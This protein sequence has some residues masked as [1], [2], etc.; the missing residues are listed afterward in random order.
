MSWTTPADLCVQVQRLW[1]RG[2]LLRA[3]VS[4]AAPWPVRLTLKSPSAADLS[5]C[6][7]SVRDWVR[8][9]AGTPHVRIEWREWN[10]RVQGMQ[11]LPAA[12]WVDT[13]EAALALVGK[14]REVQRFEA[15][16]QQTV[17]VQPALREWV[18]RRPLQA[19]DLA[20]RWER[21]LAVVA[22]LQAHPQPAVYLRQVDAQGVDSKFIEAHRGVLTELLDLALP[23]EAVDTRAS[24]TAQFAR[25]FGFLEK[26]V[27][28]RFRLLDPAMPSLPGCH[29]QPDITLDATSF[30]A[31]A[32]PI[33]RLFITENETNFL[34]FPQMEKAIVVFGAGYGWDALARA[35][36]LHRCR[37][38]YWGDIDTHGF[39]ILD[40]LR[41][42]FPHVA[43]LLM[44]RETLLAHRL[45]W[46]E[47]PEPARHDLSRLTTDES[48]IY[49][50]LRFDCLQPRLRLEQER[51][52]Y[53]WLGD[54]LLPISLESRLSQQQQS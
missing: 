49:D 47:E 44:D 36:C 37:L 22:W 8:A 3:S 52:G 19:L 14:A 54:R 41:G 10:H 20:D 39:A 25:R 33:D 32:L 15:L 53:D 5:D 31:L 30:A 23:P 38:Y 13:L 35:T 45:H 16:W 26:P 24:G 11:R 6:F 18:R 12:V 48:A 51:I 43:S 27:R 2:D 40:Q 1:D 34:A 29:E 21:L 4:D 50:E 42:Y 9:V 7:E 46:G 17:A 28:I